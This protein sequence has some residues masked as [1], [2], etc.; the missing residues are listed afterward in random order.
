[1]PSYSSTSEWKQ[2]MSARNNTKY[3]E[4]VICKDCEVQPEF[5]VDE[6]CKKTKL[7]QFKWKCKMCG[8]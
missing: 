3:Y 1:M 2:K 4:S 8:S 5:T 6:Y 7:T